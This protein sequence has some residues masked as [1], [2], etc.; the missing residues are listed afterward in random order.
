MLDENAS[1]EKSLERKAG[2][3]FEE[4]PTAAALATKN[5]LAGVKNHTIKSIDD[6]DQA[7]SFSKATH[8]DVPKQSVYTHKKNE[9]TQ[10][11][12]ATISVQVNVVE[13]KTNQSQPP[14]KVE[15]KPLTPQQTM[16]KIVVDQYKN[17]Q[18]A[19]QPLAVVDNKSQP[20]SQPQIE[21]KP[22]PVAEV[23]A[24]PVVE[25]K[26]LL[27][28]EPKV[29]PAVE[30]KPSTTVDTTSVVEQKPLPAVESKVLPVIEQKPAPVAEIAPQALSTE[31]PPVN[32]LK[33]QTVED[34]HSETDKEMEERKERIHA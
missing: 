1:L 2:K 21:I 18:Q 17:T 7:L 9:F 8:K 34:L 31:V 12:N 27:V 20:I 29:L 13:N 28:S 25:Q 30:Q 10:N 11:L 3:L 24:L 19:M 5:I 6:I 33:I 4:D 16:A 15:Q 14:P 32:K 26:P 22:A 23:K